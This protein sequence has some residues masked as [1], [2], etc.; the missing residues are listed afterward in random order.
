MSA[1]LF[2]A[3]PGRDLCVG[4]DTYNSTPL[5]DTGHNVACEARAARGNLTVLQSDDLVINLWRC[6][7]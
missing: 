3:T 2:E 7:S 4:S 6:V 1:R 5:L